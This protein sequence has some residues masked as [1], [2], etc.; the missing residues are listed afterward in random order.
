MRGY[1]AAEFRTCGKPSCACAREREKR[2]GPYWYLYWTEH[3]KRRKIYV[4][5][6]HVESLRQ[7]LDIARA[8]RA[9]M[10]EARDTE[11][12]MQAI[13]AGQMPAGTG[14][15]QRT[16][17]PM[18]AAETST[19]SAS[20]AAASPSAPASFVEFLDKRRNISDEESRDRACRAAE[21]LFKPTT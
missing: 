11:R 18:F 21:K 4:P 10:Q 19:M 6:D 5:A 13:A 7:A 20:P 16:A 3:G 9:A 14:R 1:L 8:S 17:K 15:K 2:H 12:W